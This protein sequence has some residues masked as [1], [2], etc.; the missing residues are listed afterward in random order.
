MDYCWCRRK[1]AVERFYNLQVDH[2]HST[3]GCAALSAALSA[4]SAVAHFCI[5]RFLFIR[6]CNAAEG[7]YQ[8]CLRSVKRLSPCNVCVVLGVAIHTKPLT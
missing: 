1:Y 7:N 5:P 4:K 6:W 3:S 8:H 2:T